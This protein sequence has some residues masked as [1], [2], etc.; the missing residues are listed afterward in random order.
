[1]ENR[2]QRAALAA[3]F[4]A[5]ALGASSGAMAS[6][7]DKARVSFTAAD[8]AAARAAVLHRADLGT[9]AGWTG[10]ATKPDL[11]S[12]MNCRGYAPKQSDLVVT[13]AA[14]A[15]YRHAGLVLQSQA[16]VMKTSK[17]VALDWRRTVASPKAFPCVRTML[18]KSLPKGQRLVSFRKQ[19]FPKLTQYTAAYRA[20]LDVAASGQHVAVVVDIVLVGRSRTEVSLSVGAPAAARSTL[21]VAELRL[22]RTLLARVRA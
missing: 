20:L 6:F 10:G 21:P 17:M 5:V 4:A 12:T 8:L 22:A 14:A 16:Q 11:S 18:A 15:D 19:P 2:M 3:V 13:G 1:M 9:T 7:S